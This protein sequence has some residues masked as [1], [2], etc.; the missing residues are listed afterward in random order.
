M[1]PVPQR[2]GLNPIAK[3]GRRR[4]HSAPAPRMVSGLIPRTPSSSP[5][6]RQISA[7][8]DNSSAV[9]TVLD[10]GTMVVRN[11]GLLVYGMISCTVPPI[12]L[13][14]V[15]LVDAEVRPPKAQRVEDLGGQDV[16][17]FLT[18]GRVDDLAHQR[19]PGQRVVH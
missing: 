18:R 12:A 7:N 17:N 16:A 13:R 15:V 3:S 14:K 10:D 9:D 6:R 4:R 11:R 1:N 5:P 8:R 2:A 19:T